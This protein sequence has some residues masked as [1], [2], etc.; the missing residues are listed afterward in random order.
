MNMCYGLFLEI[1]IRAMR[2]R[3]CVLYATNIVFAIND[4]GILEFG[5]RGIEDERG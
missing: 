2:E 3:Q 1:M 5:D 4:L